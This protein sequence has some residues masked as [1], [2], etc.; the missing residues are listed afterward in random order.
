MRKRNHLAVNLVAVGLTLATLATAFPARP[1]ATPRVIEITAMRFGFSPDEIT[2]KKGE[3]VTLR[4]ASRDVKHGFFSKALKLDADIVP[5]KT[6]E[7]TFAPETTGK[8]VTVCDN[9]CGAGH[10]D[11]RM[12]IVVQ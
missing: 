3:A 8:F 5:G 1:S 6:T 2:L 7:L 4:F 9:F 11:M 12:T 10:G